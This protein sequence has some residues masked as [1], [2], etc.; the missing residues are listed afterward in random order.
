MSKARTGVDC[1][2]KP[3]K[4]DE[5]AG[6]AHSAVAWVEAFA[7]LSGEALVTVDSQLRVLHWPM[8]A[9]VLLGWPAT[10]AVG[11]GLGSVLSLPSAT[12]A[13]LREAMLARATLADVAL[14]ARRIG[15]VRCLLRASL[16]PV[17]DARG[18]ML[19]AA[20]S[21][22]PEDREM[23]SAQASVAQRFDTTRKLLDLLPWPVAL[24]DALG[25]L[26]LA[27]EAA[28]KQLDLM[29]GVS[30]CTSLCT[31]GG[32]RCRSRRILATPAAPVFWEFESHGQ[33]FDMSATPVSVADGKPDHVLYLAQPAQ[34]L[35]SPELKK[36]FRAV[37]EN[38]SGVVIAD[39]NGAIEYA[40]PRASEILGYSHPE[41]I[42]RDVR[43][44]PTA[45]GEPGLDMEDQPLRQGTMEMTV[46][47]ADGDPR[48]V[49]VVVSDIRAEDGRVSNWMFLFDDITTRRALEASE[50][51]L[52][53]QVAHAARLAAV[54]EIASMI[55]HEINQPLASIANYGRGM[56]LRLDRG[57]AD[58]ASLREALSEI[59]GQVDRAGTIVQNVRGLVRRRPASTQAVDLNVL[60]ESLQ[61][62]FRL[63]AGGTKVR[64]ELELDERSGR[65]GIDPTQIE[66]VLVNLVKNAIEASLAL[67]E[68][69]RRVTV[70]TRALV[71][72][73]VGVEVEDRAAMPPEDMLERIGKP[74]F[75]TKPEGLG[76]GLSIS[77]TLLEY[78]GTRLGILPLQDDGKVFHFE[79][80][81]ANDDY[82][83]E[84]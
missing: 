83:N 67:A 69:E 47:R 31:R 3:D 10:R 43:T 51:E 27:N 40:N 68:N 20:V 38:M 54:G 26:V 77:R 61:P 58:E 44:F 75:T 30:C 13:A 21:L 9:E 33:R 42:G 41:L 84:S 36:F 79:L 24:A 8:A 6:T 66:Q 73:G 82:P 57:K 60:I 1:L 63:L 17:V 29:E 25:T 28:R 81:N 48:R 12:Q 52:R 16:R 15:G 78:H 2:A 50:R 5:D 55:A 59:V 72:A 22:R 7:D 56:L 76:L 18:V 34:S 39:E 65:V 70:R 53:E 11:F 49:R 45:P 4:P 71:P 62:T 19:G 32:D 80:K 46:H 74:F 23:P 35:L 37:N 64:V 14:P